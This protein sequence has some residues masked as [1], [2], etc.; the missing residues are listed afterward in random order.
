MQ[1]V[2]NTEIDGWERISFGG[3]QCSSFFIKNFSG[4]EVYVSFCECIRDTDNCFCIPAGMAEEVYVS[5]ELD[6]RTDGIWLCG[7]GRVEV[8][9]L[10]WRP[11]I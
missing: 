7:S 3:I 8:E 9:A 11:A 5:D 4:A 2:K 6:A 10:S 1:K